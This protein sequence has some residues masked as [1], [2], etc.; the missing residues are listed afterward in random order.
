MI[1]FTPSP[2]G[3][4]WVACAGII[5]TERRSS[6][7]PL[8]FDR[9]VYALGSK[10]SLTIAVLCQKNVCAQEGIAFQSKI[11]LVVAKSKAI[12]PVAGTHTHVLVDQWFH[13]KRIRKAAQVRNWDLS[14]GLKSNQVMRLIG[15]VAAKM[16]AE[17]GFP[18]PLRMLS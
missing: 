18:C 13:Y 2:K 10:I 11:N 6:Q 16:A 5:P 17:N 4:R 8:L 7:W 12:D 1:Q 15:T 9:L 14:A 3:V